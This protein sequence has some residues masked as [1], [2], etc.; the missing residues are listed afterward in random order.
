VYAEELAAL[1]FPQEIFDC[2]LLA[3]LLKASSAASRGGSCWLL[4]IRYS[5]CFRSSAKTPRPFR[6]GVV[7]DE[8]VAD[9]SP[10]V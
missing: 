10:P 1:G 3:T 4:A 9:R 5:R 2:R 6:R 7:P 8:F